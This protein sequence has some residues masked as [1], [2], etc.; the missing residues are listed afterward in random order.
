MKDW[1]DNKQQREQTLYE[2]RL[3]EMELTEEICDDCGC[4]LNDHGHCPRCDY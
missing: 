2:M 4:R 3:N 1:Q